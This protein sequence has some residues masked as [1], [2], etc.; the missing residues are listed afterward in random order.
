MKVFIDFYN[1]IYHLGNEDPS[2]I[3][4]K[5]ELA[6]VNDNLINTIA[7]NTSAQ[8]SDGLKCFDFKEDEIKKVA[9]ELNE[10]RIWIDYI[11]ILKDFSEQ[12]NPKKIR[13]FR[14]LIQ[15]IR[16]VNLADMLNQLLKKKNNS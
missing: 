16:L 11:E 3:C 15:P 1:Y 13:R 2:Q 10:N 14:R 9:S 6:G 12:S 7:K 5:L 8:S 4:K